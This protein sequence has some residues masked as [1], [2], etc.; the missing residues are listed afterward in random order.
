MRHVDDTYSII[1]NIKKIQ[2]RVLE[3]QG[4]VVFIK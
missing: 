3:I 1:Y 4:W 2:L